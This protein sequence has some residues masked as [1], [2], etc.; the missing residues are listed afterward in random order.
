MMSE[1]NKIETPDAFFPNLDARFFV[2]E[3][4]TNIM[5]KRL[6]LTDT[7]LEDLDEVVRQVSAKEE[8][9]KEDRLALQKSIIRHVEKMKQQ[10]NT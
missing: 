10:L 3:I 7:M 5:V 2:L 1:K 9:Q 4:M 8:F 6:G